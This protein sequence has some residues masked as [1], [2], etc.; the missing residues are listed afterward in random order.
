VTTGFTGPPPDSEDFGPDSED[1][2]FDA[3]PLWEDTRGGGQ[4][5]VI[6]LGG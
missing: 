6:V 1:T 2:G 3:C 4:G 5:S